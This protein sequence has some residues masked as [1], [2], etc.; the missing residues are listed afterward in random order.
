MS[1]EEQ[2]SASPQ[3]KAAAHLSYVNERTAKFVP[4]LHTRCGGS[5]ILLCNLYT[6]HC[7]YYHLHLF[8]ARTF[9]VHQVLPKQE[10]DATW[11]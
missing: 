2:I 3:T 9:L 5:V 7:C 8:T 11:I 10:A 6:L 4:D 1:P